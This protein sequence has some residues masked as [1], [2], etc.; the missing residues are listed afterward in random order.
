MKLPP[1]IKILQRVVKQHH[2]LSD[3]FYDSKLSAE[4]KAVCYG[5]IRWYIQLEAILEKLLHEPLKDKNFP[6]A[7]HLYIGLFQIR[8]GDKPDFAVVKEVVNSIKESKFRWAEGL[9][10][11]LLR[12]F[13]DEQDA[14][15]DS[16][17]KN[18]TAFYAHPW[19]MIEKIGRDTAILDANNVQAPMTLRVNLQQTTRDD[20]LKQLKAAGIAAAALSSSAT[21]LQLDQAIS[22][23]ELP[24]FFE[25][26][27]SVQDEAGQLVAS[28]LALETGQRVLDAC[29]APGSKT[30]HILELMPQLKQLTAIDIDGERLKKVNDN[31][32]RLKLNTEITQLIAADAGDPDQWWDGNLFDRILIDAPCSASGVIRRHPDIKLLRRE[33][34]IAALAE[35]Q[36]QLLTSLSR[37]VTDNGRIVYSTCSIF[38]EENSNIVKQF[39]ER[40]G[41]RL[42]NE[43]QL[44]PTVNSHDGFYI[45]TLTN[46]NY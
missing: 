31:L 3:C 7:L 23:E 28:Q 12:R 10:N 35:R 32:N 17:K 5:V 37:L 44:A 41:F 26:L 36:L 29:C 14:I 34:D 11:K 43:Q 18:L 24:G 15:V 42:E 27:C 21:A 25:G 8:Y 38:N 1:I 4:Q 33:T 30:G 40:S 19:W 2:S 46:N 22:V 20:Y 13:I 39:C 16:I 6:V 9:T 45:A